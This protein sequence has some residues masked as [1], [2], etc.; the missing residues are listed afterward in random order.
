MFLVRWLRSLASL[1]ILW[2]GQLALALKQPAGTAL[3]SAA[4]AVSRD[5][6]VGN[7]ALA[8]TY[9]MK[10]REAALAQARAWLERHP[11]PGFAALA[12]LLCLDA[13]ALE[14]A[15]DFLACGR[16]L[17]DDATGG[18]DRLDYRIAG[19][20]GNALEVARQLDARTDLPPD[21]SKTVCTEL[22]FD[23][24]M[25]GRFD[26]AK[27]RAE[28]LLEVGE[29]AASE[30]VLWA[31]ATR[32]GDQVAAEGHYGRAHLPPAQKSFYAFLGYAAIGS[33]A[34]AQE[35]L[36]ELRG[37]DQA[38][39]LQAEGIVKTRE[40]LYVA[41]NDAAVRAGAAGGDHGA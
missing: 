8:A 35:V 39:A 14:E 28:H 7:A 25:N 1:P 2:L 9:Q 15:R 13:G 33:S 11:R 22:M 30:L 16:Q 4:W 10:G 29:D 26:D 6:G 17:G 37:Q 38:L 31:L 34:A 12:G 3:L 19:R 27:R 21:L 24:L 5:A 23:D 18:L 36:A 20:S 32:A 40:S 41:G